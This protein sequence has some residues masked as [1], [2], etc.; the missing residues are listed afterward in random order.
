MQ[1]EIVIA[2]ISALTAVAASIFTIS[3]QARL[4]KLQA[5]LMEKQDERRKK[6]EAEAMISKY[7]EPLVNAAYE[8][9]GRL[10]NI[11]QLNFLK[12]FYQNGN[13]REKQY[14][15]ENTVYVI[16]QYFGWSEIIRRDVQFLDLG[17]AEATKQLRVLQDYICNLFLDSALENVLRIFRGDQ[18]AIGELMIITTPSG[19]VTCMGYAQFFQKR[20]PDFQYWFEPLRKDIDLLARELPEYMPKIIRLQGALVDLL[21]FLDP[22]YVRYPKERR[23][24]LQLEG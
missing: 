22:H 18:R 12:L 8:L 23:G 24:K 20:E 1:I 3:G 5:D 6:N 9:Q 2:I 7:R 17:E 10:F 4:T 21:D 11:A 19:G 16:A 14:A 13:E 15:I